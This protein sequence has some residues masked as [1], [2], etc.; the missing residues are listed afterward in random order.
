MIRAVAKAAAR[1]GAIRLV[2]KPHPSEQMSELRRLFGASVETIIV[3]QRQDITP[4]ILACDVMI[5][6]FSQSALQ[7]LYVG[8][9]VVNVDFP[10]S[11]G[12]TI[13]SESRATWTARST[14]DI[15][16]HLSR[17]TGSDRNE[18]IASREVARQRFIRDWVHTPDGHAAERVLEVIRYLLMSDRSS[19]GCQPV[20][21]PKVIQA[22]PLS[23][24]G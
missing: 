6:F 9:P 3:D 13:Y 11:G 1:T 20:S 21:G 2:I 23:I 24:R 18:E 15:V 17:L 12:A 10:G 5:T 16:T 19:K 8:I 4:L 14:D 7:A 22:S